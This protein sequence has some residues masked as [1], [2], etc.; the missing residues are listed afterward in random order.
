MQ[1]KILTRNIVYI[2]TRKYNL[3]L[4]INM[5]NPE[6]QSLIEHLEELR[7]RVII[8]I[9]AVFICA[10]VSFSFSDDVI[11]KNGGLSYRQIQHKSGKF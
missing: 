9:V 11:K 4:R 3:D 7:W 2:A 10:A 5:T 6:K 1:R 8:C